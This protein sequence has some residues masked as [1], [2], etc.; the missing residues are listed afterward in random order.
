MPKRRELKRKRV[1][2]TRIIEVDGDVYLIT[3]RDPEGF[4]AV[5][6]DPN[7]AERVRRMRDDNEV[8]MESAVLAR[9]G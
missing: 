9:R 7:D 8:E 2:R 3:D 4:A 1:Y 5:R 6:L